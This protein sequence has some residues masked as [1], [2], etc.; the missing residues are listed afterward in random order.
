[1]ENPFLNQ[2]GDYPQSLWM[3]CFKI[4]RACVPKAERPLPCQFKHSVD[5]LCTGAQF[6]LVDENICVK[7]NS[8]KYMV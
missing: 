2:P 4:R 3:I 5:I 8:H 1:M 6:S 7:C